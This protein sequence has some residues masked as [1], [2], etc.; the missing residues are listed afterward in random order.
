MTETR[1]S[2]DNISK[3]EI[4]IKIDDNRRIG[5]VAVKVRRNYITGLRLQDKQDEVLVEHV[6]G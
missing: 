2:Y 4:K 3:G 6:W 5:R 1:D